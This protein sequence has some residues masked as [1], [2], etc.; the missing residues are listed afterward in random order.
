MLD[1]CNIGPYASGDNKIFSQLEPD[2]VGLNHILHCRT[3]R[4]AWEKVRRQ[5]EPDFAQE[6]RQQVWHSAVQ[7]HS[8]EG[9]EMLRSGGVEKWRQTLEEIRAQVE[10][11]DPA[12][13]PYVHKFGRRKNHASDA[14]RM[15]DEVRVCK[16]GLR[17]S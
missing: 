1:V 14:P 16:A 8:L 10:A 4:E 7:L 17:P 15:A 2:Q 5:I 9:L 13:R 12:S 11:L 6:G 3:W